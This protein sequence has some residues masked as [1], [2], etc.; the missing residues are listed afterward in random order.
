MC[1]LIFAV[2]ELFVWFSVHFPCISVLC[3]LDTA[4]L[5]TR[6]CYVILVAFNK[7]EDVVFIMVSDDDGDCSKKVEWVSQLQW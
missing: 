5:D 2:S 7:E 4:E 1:S 6:K 3:V